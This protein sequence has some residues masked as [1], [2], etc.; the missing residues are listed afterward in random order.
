MRNKFASV[1][2]IAASLGLGTAAMAQTLVGQQAA[3]VIT[4]VNAA[5]KTVQL[6]SGQVFLLPSNFNTSMLS[7]GQNVALNWTQDGNGMRVTS[8]NNM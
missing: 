1:L 4:V 2:I 6:T 7:E 5:D 3:G 8:I